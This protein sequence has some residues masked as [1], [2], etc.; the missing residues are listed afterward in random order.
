MFQRI[1]P[2]L[3]AAALLVLPAFASAEPTEANPLKCETCE[4]DCEARGLQVGERYCSGPDGLAAS[5]DGL[6]IEA[7]SDQTVAQRQAPTQQQ[8][9]QQQQ[10]PRLEAPA[11]GA[12][13]QGINV[14][15]AQ[16]RFVAGVEVVQTT[17]FISVAQ[18]QSLLGARSEA[19]LDCFEPRDYR[20][21]GE[22]LVNLYV[23]PT[24]LT[25]GIR[26]DSDGIA[27]AQARCIMGQAW[28]YAFSA[29]PTNEETALV[30]YRVFF[31][32]ER[33]F[34]SPLDGGGPNLIVERVRVDDQGVSRAELTSSLVNQA[35]NT[36]ACHAI[37]L[38]ELPG[39][40]V[41]ADVEMSF[42]RYGT[43]YRASEVDI[44]LTNES[45]TLMPSPELVE[46]VR[47]S[48]ATWR[49][50]LPPTVAES[51][52]SRFFVTF[53]PPAGPQS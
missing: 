17:E 44:T 31:A 24:G 40:L 48:L 45:S 1:L 6:R 36:R 19:L 13:G 10:P 28:D 49:V 9:Q 14:T 20:A 30:Q 37:A 4:T 27:P 34:T 46:C 51:F 26:G 21:D 23:G 42:E 2:A 33:E 7:A 50:S 47:Q 38:E 15:G 18:A 39:D 16:W 22:M 53:Q 52:T 12:R 29:P 11:P 41:V 25:R 43:V 32:A 8:Q 5:R 35:Q 3:V